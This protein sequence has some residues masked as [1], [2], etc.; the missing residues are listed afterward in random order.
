MM[1][2]VVK[3]ETAEDDAAQQKGNLH[4]S[5]S[6]NQNVHRCWIPERKRRWPLL[7]RVAGVFALVQID[8][9]E[10]ILLQASDFR[11][12]SPA[13]SY[14]AA[15]WRGSAMKHATLWLIVITLS[16]ATPG[17]TPKYHNAPVSFD[18]YLLSLSWAP[19]YCAEHPT[20][21]SKECKPGNHTAFVLHGLWPSNNEGKQPVSCEKTKP[22]PARVV[23]H[24]MQYFP[25]RALIHH[26]WVRHGT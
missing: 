23:Q 18:Y 10:S 20:D 2:A 7:W 21:K 12:A 8:S 5:A 14:N 15:R 25:S 9:R 13:S 19:S 22:V 1:D 26:E 16:L 11:C 3:K 6:R 17:Q 24:M 4:A